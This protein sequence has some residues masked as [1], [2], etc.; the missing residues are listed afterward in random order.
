LNNEVISIAQDEFG[1]SW[2]GTYNGANRL[3][4][5]PFELFN[6]NNHRQ[7]HSIVAIE[8]LPGHG[9]LIASYGGLLLFDELSG[10]HVPIKDRFP[11][12]ELRNE[13]IMSLLV[14]DS[15]IFIG[16]RFSGVEVFDT[17][18]LEKTLINTTTN[19]K[20]KSNSISNLLILKSGE[21]I[22]GTYGGGL[23]II[24]NDGNSALIQT[25][26]SS[27]SLNDDRVIMLYQSSDERIWVGTEVGLQ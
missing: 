19:P 2:I 8:S 24:D 9:N 21:L 1:N 6:R 7:L 15:R 3:I 23:I 25:D 14:K 17:K 26:S 18:S 16:Y 20:M 11:A 13:R 4:T 5:S 22:V 12:L 27:Q 10:E